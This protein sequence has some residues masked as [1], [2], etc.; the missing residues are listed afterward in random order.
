MNEEFQ[1]TINSLYSLKKAVEKVA[2]DE[3]NLSD[4]KGVKAPALYP[5]DFLDMIGFII[6]KIE[7]YGEVELTDDEISELSFLPIRIDNIKENIVPHLFGNNSSDAISSFV[8]TIAFITQYLDDIFSLERLDNA[9]LLPRNMTR[10]IKSMEARLNKAAPDIESLENKINKINDAHVAAE[11]IPID[12]EE[13]RSYNKEAMELKEK[14]NKSMFN[15]SVLEEKGRDIL[16][17]MTQQNVEA[18]KYLEMCEQAIR[19][20]TSKGLA[21]A[22]EIKANKLNNSIQLWVL[23]LASALAT[24]G[25]VGFERLKVLSDV[26]N[27]ANPNAVVIVTQLLLS[28]FSIGA[29]LWFAWLSTKQINQRF[30]LAEDYAFKASVAK[31]YEG[32]RNEASK[33]SNGEFE[34]RLFDSALSRLEEAP[35]RFVK[36]DDHA[37]PWNELLNSKAFNKFLD[38]SVEN[39]NFVKGIIS[40]KTG[41]ARMASNDSAIIPEKKV[42]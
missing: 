24:G 13:L 19:A 20:S 17:K 32:Y 5:L 26:L 7:K 40:K 41:G 3:T 16:D 12:L 30:K 6:R 15:L 4:V 11:N 36:D 33:V 29:P 28:V 9:N 27:N 35:L 8:E 18:A 2:T 42:E 21:G 10:K 23:G 25:Y 22:F 37:T 34:R 39:V 31:A 38:A 1:K 14:I